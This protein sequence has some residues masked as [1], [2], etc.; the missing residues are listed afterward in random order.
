[1]SETPI[2][3]KFHILAQITRAS[4]F[5]WRQAVAE[6]FP[7]ADIEAVV[8]RM[9]E[10]TGVETGQA[11]LRKIDP[12]KSLPLQVAASIVWSSDS[13]GETAE[14]VKGEN[15]NEAFVKHTGCPWFEWHQ[16]LGLLP[17]DRS[18]CDKWFELLID[19]I[20]KKL[21]TKLKFETIESLPEGGNTCLRRIYL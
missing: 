9:W 12:D 3:R 17:E 21:G 6:M 15:A 16:R 11:Y 14:L 13:M 18:G 5:A 10:I 8:Y 19:T 20:N 4:H 1:M 7:D 2:E